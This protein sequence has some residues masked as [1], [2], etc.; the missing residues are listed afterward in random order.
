M[1]F[2]PNDYPDTASGGLIEKL[3]M[4]K[5]EVFFTLS[6]ITTKPTPDVSKERLWKGRGLIVT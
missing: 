2:N 1:V 3:V 6:A 5:Q 4:T